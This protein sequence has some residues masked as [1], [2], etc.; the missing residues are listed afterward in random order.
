MRDSITLHALRTHGPVAALKSGS[1]EPRESVRQ[2]E[3][4]S[5]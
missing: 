3:Q 5:S 1:T 2:K 4:L